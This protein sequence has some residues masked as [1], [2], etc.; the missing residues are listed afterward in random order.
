MPSIISQLL[1]NMGSRSNESDAFDS[2][3]SSMG[4]ASWVNHFSTSKSADASESAVPSKSVCNAVVGPGT[5]GVVRPKTEDYLLDGTYLPHDFNVMY[6]SMLQF[7]IDDSAEPLTFHHDAP[8]PPMPVIKTYTKRPVTAVLSRV[9]RNGDP[10]SGL[11]TRGTSQMKEKKKERI[12]LNGAIMGQS[13]ASSADER[14][15]LVVAKTGQVVGKT[16]AATADNFDRAIADRIEEENSDGYGVGGTG[17]VGGKIEKTKPK[18]QS[19]R[20]TAPKR[21]RYC[22]LCA[23]HDKTV[24]MI[25]CGNIK[26]GTCQKSVCVK[27]IELHAL[28]T[29]APDWACPH[30]QNKCPSRAKCFSYDKQTAQRREKLKRVKAENGSKRC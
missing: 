14:M 17:S 28:Q 8:L 23:R 15:L 10:A 18:R 11:Q 21:S 1:Q 16:E 29:D 27:C 30:C 20:Y 4:P 25:G 5:A 24:D 13:S 7:N 3:F 9:H 2:L 19:R 6:P 22:H 26:K 12:V